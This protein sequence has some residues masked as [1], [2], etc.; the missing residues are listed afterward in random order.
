M[1][2][3]VGR[4]GQPRPSADD[5]TARKADLLRVA[6]SYD[7][8]QPSTPFNRAQP[9]SSAAWALALNPSVSQRRAKEGEAIVNSYVKR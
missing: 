6:G 8:F 4:D 5:G 2:S 7:L 9:T 3:L 1:A